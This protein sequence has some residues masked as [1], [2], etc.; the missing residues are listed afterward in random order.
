[1]DLL[2]TVAGHQ[3]PAVEITHGPS[4]AAVTASADCPLRVRSDEP[5]ADPSFDLRTAPE[6][7]SD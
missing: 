4:D 3:Y 6:R 7:R 5:I 1:M 2:V